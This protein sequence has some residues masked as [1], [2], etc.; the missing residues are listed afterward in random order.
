MTVDPFPGNLTPLAVQAGVPDWT[1]YKGSA[2]HTGYVPLSLD[3]RGFSKRWLWRGFR[4]EAVNGYAYA[5]ISPMNPVAVADAKVYIST[6]TRFEDTRL[7]AL[8]EQDGH[9]IW[10]RLIGTML[11]PT[12]VAVAGGRLWLA[13]TAN[14][15]TFSPDDGTELSRTPRSTQHGHYY[16]PT[17][18]GDTIYVAGHVLGGLPA[19][20]T[21]TAAARWAF[22]TSDYATEWTPAADTDYVYAYGLRCTACGLQV[23]NRATAAAHS[24][25]MTVAFPSSAT[26]GCPRRARSRE[27]PCSVGR[28]GSF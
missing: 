26:I 6:R 12:P 18:L 11:E 25:S 1:T 5:Y 23:Y 17:P 24:A 21:S 16:A 2:A 20:D 14:V 4:R 15:R 28:T 13:D 9:E 19:D 10:S 7:Y 27:R 22:S 3:A 8:D